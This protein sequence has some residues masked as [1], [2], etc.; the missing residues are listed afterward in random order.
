MSISA[1]YSATGAAWQRGPGRVYD[2]LAEVLVAASPISLAGRRVLDVG[3]GTGAASRAIARAGGRVIAVDL[4]EGMLRVDQG[5]RAPAAVADGRGLPVAT[6]SC[7][8]VVA[9]FS[10]NHVPDP[11]LALAEAARVVAPGGV[12]LVS[13]YAEDDGH[14]VKAAADAAAAEAGWQRDRWADDLRTD[15][16]PQL[17]SAERALIASQ[18]AGL[19]AEAHIVD[20]PF[21]HLGAEDL[22]AWR[23]GMPTLAPFVASLPAKQRRAVTARALA[24]LGEPPVLVR[25]MVI[26]TAPV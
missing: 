20:V 12:V 21:P 15:A 2:H 6:D 8:A 19:V 26:V 16:M 25:R 4:A 11:H 7:G 13:A 17:A 1:A 3:A 23:M 24:L 18:R 10:Y 14:P 5:Q 22:V 9:A